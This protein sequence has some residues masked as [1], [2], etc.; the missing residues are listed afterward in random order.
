MLK[1]QIIHRTG[2][3]TDFAAEKWPEKMEGVYIF[4]IDHGYY[5]HVPVDSIEVV[6]MEW[7]ADD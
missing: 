7:E 3:T 5:V 2:R 1:V 6:T 4:K